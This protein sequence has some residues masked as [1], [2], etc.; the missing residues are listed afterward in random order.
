MGKQTILLEESDIKFITDSRGN[1]K[2]VIISYDK[3]KELIQI[4]EDHIFLHSPEIQEQ[5]R[6]S[7]EDIKAGR[8]V[9]AKGSE[10]DKLLE[11][12]HE[13]EEW[14]KNENKILF[15]YRHGSYGIL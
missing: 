3:F 13:R 5:L 7:E 10:I 12:L 9:K 2:E 11:C 4:I 1:R 15:R 6:Q 8:Y 14:G